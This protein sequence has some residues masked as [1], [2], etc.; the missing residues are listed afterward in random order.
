M[1]LPSRVFHAVD[2][3]PAFRRLSRPGGSIRRYLADFLDTT[4]HIIASLVYLYKRGF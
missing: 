3:I 2:G 4:R 1:R